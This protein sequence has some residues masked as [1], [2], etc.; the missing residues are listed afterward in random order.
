MCPCANAWQSEYLHKRL[1]QKWVK[2]KNYKDQH[3]GFSVVVCGEYRKLVNRSYSIVLHIVSLLLWSQ[4]QSL[5]KV[6]K[7]TLCWNPVFILLPR[8]NFK[9]S[10]NSEH[11][12]KAKGFRWF[13]SQ[14]HKYT[15]ANLE[16]LK[17]LNGNRGKFIPFNLGFDGCGNLGRP[18]K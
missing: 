7:S 12:W 13:F 3:L 9:I 17:D 4:Y 2:T 11:F 14:V 16:V 18:G 1:K 10:P 5:Y 15:C 8:P 6:T